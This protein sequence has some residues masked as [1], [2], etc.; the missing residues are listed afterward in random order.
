M[1]AVVDMTRLMPCQEHPHRMSDFEYDGLFTTDKP[2]IFACH[3]CPGLIRRLAQ[4]HAL[5]GCR[6][7]PAC[8]CKRP[9]PSA[10]MTGGSQACGTTA[11]GQVAW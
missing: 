8:Q 3:G 2:V 4:R 1:K 11:T 10:A 6:E 5:A 9:P 7:A